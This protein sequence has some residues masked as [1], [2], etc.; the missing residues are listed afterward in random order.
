MTG[1]A[2]ASRCSAA[3]KFQE[4]YSADIDSDFVAEV[5]SFRRE[6]QGEIETS[7]CSLLCTLTDFLTQP[8]V[9][10]VCNFEIYLY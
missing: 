5:R 3:Q 2:S 10:C 1:V 9:Y 7:M 4:T 8:I 6:L